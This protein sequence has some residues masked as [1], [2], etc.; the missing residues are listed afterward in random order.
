MSEHNILARTLRWF[1]A[2]VPNPQPK[3]QQTQIGIHFEEVAEMVACL[4]GKDR[5]TQAMLTQ[6][7]VAL[8]GLAVHL[9]SSKD[10]VVAVTDPVEMLDALCDQGVTLAGVSHME[11]YDLLGG[12][13]EVN[14]SNF[15]KFVD[16]RPIFDQNM[17]VQKGPDYFK[18]A[19]GTYVPSAAAVPVKAA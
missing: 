12:L 10:I 9:K 15:S 3:N 13:N 8:H 17:K 7:L 19:L 6:T 16:G 11:G 14:N 4:R 1:R 2:A 18:P 5:L